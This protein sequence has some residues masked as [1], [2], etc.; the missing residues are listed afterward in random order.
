MESIDCNLC[1]VVGGTVSMIILFYF[2]T[3]VA[4]VDKWVLWESKFKGNWSFLQGISHV[5]TCFM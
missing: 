5:M 2:A 1:G 4:G 3:L